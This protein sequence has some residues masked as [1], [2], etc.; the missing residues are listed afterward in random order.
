[1]STSARGR[2]ESTWVVLRSKQVEPS[3][4]LHLS[5]NCIHDLF[6]WAMRQITYEN[7]WALYARVTLPMSFHMGVTCQDVG[8]L[9]S[10]RELHPARPLTVSAI[11][12]TTHCRGLRQSRI[13]HTP[14]H[15]E[16]DILKTCNEAI[17]VCCR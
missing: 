10:L 7:L 12:C 9:M 1:M 16:L 11:G 4:H 17:I 6:A 8:G 15:A 13:L 14:P 5:G 2:T 3:Q